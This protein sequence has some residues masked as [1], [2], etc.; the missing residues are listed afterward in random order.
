MNYLE[1]VIHNNITS[2]KKETMM[3]SF[4]KI[5]EMKMR[6]KERNWILTCLDCRYKLMLDFGRRV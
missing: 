1:Y 3:M 2:V 4:C 5:L 6:T